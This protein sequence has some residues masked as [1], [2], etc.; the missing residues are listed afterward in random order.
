VLLDRYY[1]NR[2]SFD[3]LQSRNFMEHVE[4]RLPLYLLWFKNAA[5]QYRIDWRLLAAMGYQES[6]WDP[7]AVSF[8]GARGLMQLTAGT[9]E[10][11]RYR[12]RHDPQ[13]SIIGG[14][15][16]LARVMEMVPTRI[17]EPDRTWF[18]VAS[19][20]VGYGHVEDA[21]KLAQQLGRDP[22]RWEDVR[23]TLPLLSQEKWYTRT[24]HGYARGWEPVRYVENV[25]A[26]LDVLEVMGTGSPAPTGA[27]VSAS[28]LRSTTP[29]PPRAP[30]KR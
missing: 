17:P 14:A 28:E 23:E 12:D 1:G 7:S 4:S 6:K 29:E 13:A 10:M 30:P 25:Q 5:L 11:M 26:Y 2:D 15:K 9:A 8:S 21:R 27:E 3:Y 16:Y 22:D 20:N 18:A 19:Y 24:R